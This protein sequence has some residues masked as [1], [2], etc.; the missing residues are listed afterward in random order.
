M[1]RFL[2]VLRHEETAGVEKQHPC[3]GV[4]AADL[5]CAVA[6]VGA[7][8]DDDDREGTAADRLVP[9]VGDEP[10]DRV[11]G[12]G[13]LLYVDL[14]ARGHGSRQRH[15]GHDRRSA[16]GGTAPGRTDRGE[17]SAAAEERGQAGATTGD[18]V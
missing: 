4:G 3:V 10:A 16:G 15:G 18:D 6:P 13:R 11:G 2:D 8:P 1:P 9:G 12:E 17:L 5:R 7:G 14:I